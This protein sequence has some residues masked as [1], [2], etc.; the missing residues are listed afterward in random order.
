MA[1][2]VRSAQTSESRGTQVSWLVATMILGATF[3]GVKVIEYSDKFAHNNV[4]GPNFVWDGQYPA[5]AEIFYSLYFCMTGL[6]ALH[7]V[8]GLGI[9]TVIAIM[10]WRRQFNTEYFTPVGDRRPLLALRRHRLDLPLPAAVPDRAALRG[11]LTSC[12][13]TTSNTT[14]RRRACTT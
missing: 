1:L 3:L 11:P 5:G 8:I 2:A 9:M 7:M 6:H 10:A 4:P 12:Q 13:V 14:S